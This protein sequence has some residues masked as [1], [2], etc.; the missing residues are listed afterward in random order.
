MSVIGRAIAAGLLVWAMMGRH[1]SEYYLL[2]RCVTCLAAV[3]SAYIGAIQKKHVWVLVFGGVAVVFNP[4]LRVHLERNTSDLMNLAAAFLL[5]GSMGAVRET[6]GSPEISGRRASTIAAAWGIAETLAVVVLLSLVGVY[7]QGTTLPPAEQVDSTDDPGP[8]DPVTQAAPPTAPAPQAS[9]RSE[10]PGWAQEAAAAAAADAAS[11]SVEGPLKVGLELLQGDNVAEAQAVFVALAAKNPNVPEIHYNLGQTHLRT[12]DKAAAEAAYRKALEA[13][14][15]YVEGYVA[16]SNLYMRT[17]RKAKALELIQKAAADKPGE[18]KLQFQLGVV[19]FDSNQHAA[20][21]AALITALA[22]DPALSE[23]NYYLG[24][25]AATQSRVAEAVSYLQ[26]Y[27]ASNP[28]AGPNRHG[29]ERLM[30]YLKPN[31]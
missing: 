13:D 18:A 17:R 28:P 10:A 15:G 9:A 14:A 2:M 3:F 27:L 30:G 26:K 19:L 6:Q 20:A 4:L 25:I 23:A 7:V 22:D 5:L 12:G 1:R 29:A 24:T 8:A 11:G 16:L 21:R 31:K